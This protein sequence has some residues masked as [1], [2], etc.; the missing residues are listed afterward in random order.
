MTIWEIDRE[1]ECLVDPE[2]GELLDYES[3]AALQMERDHKVEGMVLW[4]KNLVSDVAQMKAAESDIKERRQAKERKAERLKNY[5][6]QVLAGEKFETARCAVSY[7]KSKG[8][9]VGAGVGNWLY[10]NGYRDLVVQQ[11][12]KI[13]KRGVTD[14]IKSGVEVP[15]A[16]LVERLNMSIK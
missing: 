2:T 4:Y 1:L 9:E 6:E 13:D 14:L 16:E 7:R 5:I 12:P 3:F 11:A 8:L 10:D 15:G